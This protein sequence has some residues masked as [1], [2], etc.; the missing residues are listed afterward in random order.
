[1]RSSIVSIALIVALV[2]SYASPSNAGKPAPESELKK[3]EGTWQAKGKGP[4][5]GTITIALTRKDDKITETRFSSELDGDYKLV[6]SRR[7]ELKQDEKKR[8]LDLGSNFAEASKEAGFAEVFE[9]R[10]EG[11][12]LVLKMFPDD[13]AN[14]EQTFAEAPADK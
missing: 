11:D 3:L 13:C 12:L 7:F 2:A 14:G 6:I 5:K 10:F 1:M 9:Y 8:W 4:F